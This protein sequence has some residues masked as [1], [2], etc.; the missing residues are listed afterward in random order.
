MHKYAYTLYK[1]PV[2]PEQTNKQTPMALG[3]PG[4]ILN[5]QGMFVGNIPLVM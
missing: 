5:L 1:Y 3:L 2:L 4:G